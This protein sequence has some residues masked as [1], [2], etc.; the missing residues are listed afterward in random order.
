MIDDTL[1]ELQESIQKA[2]ESLRRE[3]AKIRTGRAH[4]SLLDSVRVDN[5][6]TQ[7]PISQVSTINVPEA[8]MLTIKPWDKSQVKAIE[9]AIV[10]SPL[11]LNPQNDGEL[12]RVPLPPLTEERRKDLVKLARAAGEDTKVAIR[13]ARREAN[14]LLD[15]FKNDKEISEDD[16]ERGKKKVDEVVQQG[17]GAVDAAVSKKEADILEV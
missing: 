7:M 11:G 6:G 14:D 16:A 9:K 15:G 12:I 10:Q 5:Y 13:H 3:L 4:P 1:E 8:R 2:Q 17:T